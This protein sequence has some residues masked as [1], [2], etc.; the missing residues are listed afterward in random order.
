MANASI[1]EICQFGNSLIAKEVG[2]VYTK[3]NLE[4]GIAFPVCLSLNE[5][6]GHFSP[7]SAE[8]SVLKDGD[9]VKM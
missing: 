5:I 2:E 4:K 6:C 1:V 7:L 9:V 8:S 3:K